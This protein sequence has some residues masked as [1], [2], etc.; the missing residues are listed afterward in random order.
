MV[1]R[2]GGA[3]RL[4]DLR[5]AGCSRRRIDAAVRA[6]DLV[7]MAHGAVAL[8]GADP[9][10]VTAVGAGASLACA[11]ALHHREVE[12]LEAPRHLHLTGPGP[13]PGRLRNVRWHRGPR[14]D[15]AL[16]LPRAAAQL[17]G[18]G[19][20][21]EG[22]V[23]V[24]ALLHTERATT[25]S[26]AAE[27]PHGRG[28]H[29]R[30]VLDHATPAADSAL[31]SVLRYHLLCAAVPDV[32]LQA[33]VPGVGHVDFLIGGWLIVETDG[34]GAHGDRTSFENDRARDATAAAQ[35]LRTLRFTWD[36]VRHRPAA[37]LACIRSVL[38]EGRSP[39]APVRP[40]PP[41]PARGPAGSR[42]GPRVARR[43]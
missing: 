15:L 21:L 34:W 10:V 31:E 20:P 24:D 9:G 18:C 16:E 35:G 2:A 42:S 25:A 26:I 28:G 39:Q 38:A 6:G 11:S 8:P 17:L 36:T 43:P 41:S 30:W 7:A 4:G 13:A 32:V 22:L 33:A 37:V 23:A 12:V 40:R 19:T 1:T 3:A 5:R 14:G 27:L 29:A